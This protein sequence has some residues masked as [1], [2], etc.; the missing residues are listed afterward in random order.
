MLLL[1]LICAAVV[2]AQRIPAAQHAALMKVYDALGNFFFFFVFFVPFRFLFA[3]NDFF[4]FSDFFFFFSILGCPDTHEKCERFPTSSPCPTRFLDCDGSA[5]TYLDVSG[6]YEHSGSIPTEIGILRSL[7]ELYLN[8]NSF[9]GTLPTQLGVLT[10]LSKL[11]ISSN[12]FSG[13]VPNEIYRLSQ[14]T[15]LSLAHNSLSGSVSTLVGNLRNLNTFYYAYNSFVGTIPTQLSLLTNLTEVWLTNNQI[16]G[17]IPSEVGLWSRLEGFYVDSNKLSGTVPTE[18]SR[19]TALAKIYVTDNRLVGPLPALATITKH[20]NASLWNCYAQFPNTS[21]TNC[22]SVCANPNCLCGE[23]RCPFDPTQLTT[24][25]APPAMT[26]QRFPT[27]APIALPTS[28]P[29]SRTTADRVVT[30][31]PASSEEL[32]IIP[33]ALGIGGGV[34]CVAI[35]VVVVCIMRREKRIAASR[36]NGEISVTNSFAGTPSAHHQQPLGQSNMFMQDPSLSTQF[37]HTPSSLP[38]TSSNVHSV[39]ASFN[40]GNSALDGSDR[41]VTTY[42]Q[43]MFLPSPMKVAVAS[44]TSYRPI[45]SV[46]SSSSLGSD[47]RS[48]APSQQYGELSLQRNVGAP[49]PYYAIDDF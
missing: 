16:S 18:I 43:N 19:L 32:P 35:V 23:K 4:F 15:W 24:G 26:F 45:Q 12:F 25:Q 33:I 48:I 11:V 21:E 29:G 28:L 13:T 1:L 5:V 40:F 8:G 46:G 20:E 37:S 22:F 27:P 2:L 9:A 31:G 49:Q 3:E 34:L 42:A 41:S 36:A 6:S 39:P 47:Q 30:D 7:T 44:S 17:T 14:L 10:A 38:S